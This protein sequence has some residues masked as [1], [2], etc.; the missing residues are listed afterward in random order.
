[1]F[2]PEKQLQYIN[3]IAHAGKVVL[4]GTDSAG[5]VWYTIKHDGS[6]CGRPLTFDQEPSLGAGQKR[7]GRFRDCDLFQHLFECA[8]ARCIA[9]GL[10]QLLEGKTGSRQTCRSPR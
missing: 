3:S 8:V 4:F 1:M 9:D 6:R 5:K 2:L 7:R 10:A